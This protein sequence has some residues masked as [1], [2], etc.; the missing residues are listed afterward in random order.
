MSEGRW[1]GWL[2]MI[3]AAVGPDVG[4]SLGIDEAV[5]WMEFIE[6]AVG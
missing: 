3:D 6:E 2:V 1:E 5:G 4:R